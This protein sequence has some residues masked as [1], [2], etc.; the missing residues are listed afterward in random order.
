MQP[1]K[2]YLA[3]DG[4]GTK[5]E[6]VLFTQRGF[7]RRRIVLGGSNPN[8]V[9]VENA[10][11]V[12]ESGVGRMLAQAPELRHVYAG[13]AGCMNPEN[14]KA[15]IGH[16]YRVFP[17]LNCVIR[18]DT[19][20]VIH[21]AECGEKCVAAIC[22][23]GSVVYAKTPDGM[24]RLGGWG[25]RFDSAG[26]GYDIGRD[27]VSAALADNDGVGPST[28]IR[29]LLEER[30]DGNVWDR[31]NRLYAMPKEQIAQLSS[32]VFEA[33]DQGDEVAEAILSRNM[34]RIA[35]LANQAFDTYDCG[36]TLVLAGGLTARQDVMQKLLFSKLRNGVMPV[37]ASLPQIYG[38]CVCCTAQFGERS[39]DFRENFEVSYTKL[40][41]ED[42]HAEN[43][44]A[45][46]EDDAHR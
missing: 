5:T 37:V 15:L 2:I 43:G 24:H 4:G 41:E 22:G 11:R 35:F 33:Y 17:S 12:L 14:Q 25:N 10:G 26:S 9:G 42:D 21:S 18:S 28:C 3:I 23:T 30:L 39:S 29:A 8:S 16:L 38:A 6:F 44:D 32:L 20:N 34:A 40:R 19:L 27:A 31:I 13:I 1:E 46:S 36:S 7:V 45:K